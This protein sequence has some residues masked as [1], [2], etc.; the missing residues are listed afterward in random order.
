MTDWGGL[1]Q[2]CE[3]DRQRLVISLRQK[4]LSAKEVGEQVGAHERNV[5]A[6][7]KRLR[8]KAAKQGYSPEHDMVHTVPDGYKVK[9]TSTL[10]KDGQPALQ[11]VKSDIDNERQMP[12]RVEAAGCLDERLR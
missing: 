8:D 11:W 5:M 6:M 10:Y 12:T 7:C 4:G 3:T 2:F 1:L 9:G